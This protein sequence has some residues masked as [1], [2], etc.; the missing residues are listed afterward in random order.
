MVRGS[1]IA[2]LVLIIAV[3]AGCVPPVGNGR[4]A[5]A[6]RVNFVINV[7]E[8]PES[9]PSSALTRVN[10]ALIEQPLRA[11][12]LVLRVSA[13]DID[14]AIETII[15]RPEGGQTA[16]TLFVPAGP[17]RV[18]EAVL[19]NEAGEALYR[20]QS[21]PT[22]VG[23]GDVITLEATL[24]RAGLLEAGTFLGTQLS[25]ST[26]EV[27][28]FGATDNGGFSS[29][30]LISNF[31][32]GG[33]VP[34]NGDDVK[35]VL[36]MINDGSAGMD[37]D[38]GTYT[39]DPGSTNAGTVEDAIIVSGGRS[40]NQGLITGAAAIGSTVTL[41]E[42]RSINPDLSTTE[43]DTYV[44][45]V[46]GTVA[47]SRTGNE[48]RFDWSFET[49]GGE[50]VEG[51]FQKAPDSSDDVSPRY[52]ATIANQ[53]L[54]L[55]SLSLTHVGQSYVET[56]LP[57]LYNTEV[58]LDGFRFAVKRG[59]INFLL[60]AEDVSSIQAT[61]FDTVDDQAVEPGI[62]NYAI[63]PAAGSGFFTDFVMLIGLEID[64]GSNVTGLGAY[65]S[66][67]PFE[68]A[69]VMGVLPTPDVSA[70]VTGGT[71]E[72]SRSGSEYTYDWSIVT[73]TLGTLT[74][75][76]TSSPD[77]EENRTRDLS[78]IDFSEATV[79]TRS[80]QQDGT[81]RVTVPFGTDLTSLT[82][83]YYLHPES[84]AN[85]SWYSPTAPVGSFGPDQAVSNPVSGGATYNFTG[86]V[87]FS[88]TD[89]LLGTLQTQIQV[90]Y[91]DVDA[92]G[93]PGIYVQ[94]SINAGSGDSEIVSVDDFVASNPPFDR[95][96]FDVAVGV[97]D[98]IPDID[99]TG[100]G[101][102]I[103]AASTAGGIRDF[104]GDVQSASPSLLDAGFT[105]VGLDFLAADRIRGFV[106]ATDSAS[107]NLYRL[108]F[109]GVTASETLD[110]TSVSTPAGLT[111]SGAGN[112][113]HGVAVGP[114]GYVY[115][116]LDQTGG[117]PQEVYL[118]KIDFE[119][120]SVVDWANLRTTT[121]FYSP[122]PPAY[123][124]YNDLLYREGSLY[125]LNQVYDGG[126]TNKPA[127]LEFDPEDLGLGVIDSFGQSDSDRNG[128]TDAYGEFLNPRRF[129]AVLNRRF[130][131]IDEGYSDTLTD[132]DQII[133]FEN[134][135]PAADWGTYG[136]RGTAADEFNFFNFS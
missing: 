79:A 42:L 62:Y 108:Y 83:T 86:P 25:L 66:P 12:E 26:L 48:Y 32:V 77:F 58:F 38:P 125:L 89:P 23:G 101:R 45:F 1:L 126:N 17:A 61:F 33:T 65:I 21:E 68:N 75:T 128:A 46:S 110:V 16:E 88:V 18:F 29:G 24:E 95:T 130:V 113:L 20:W 117:D 54:V 40:N 81:L 52:E 3:L 97:T 10:R 14:P 76:Y 120:A 50:T 56:H 87:T 70:V 122:T 57:G 84:T 31:E 134:F 100:D 8:V 91:D 49:A 119:A 133:H 106:Y 15:S 102:T 5:N 37:L 90:Y 92:V 127:I 55:N 7:P 64:Q 124:P 30:F 36:F 118:L 69:G 4:D 121:D 71:I 105:T 63:S 107:M 6:A 129:A 27:G 78:S 115:V 99:Y 72:V 28:Y 13:E 41:S 11:T 98:V 93:N 34:A 80:L 51:S 43:S 22:E 74:G 35:Y 44:Q 114:D 19:R 53:S 2:G 136:S 104:S 103:F 96:V 116:V 9:P 131:I 73:D 109:D 112:A 60:G 111:V 135:P 123:A 59:D 67:V 132:H 39:L 85:V 82:P 47:V 94:N